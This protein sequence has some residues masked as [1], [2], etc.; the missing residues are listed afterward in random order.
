MTSTDPTET[1]STFDPAEQVRR[2]ARFIE[3]H[4]PGEPS[5]S[6]GAVDTAIRLLSTPVK[7]DAAQAAEEV[8]MALG[9]A[10]VCWG[11]PGPGQS[12]FESERAAQIGRDLL[13]RLGY[14]IPVGYRA[15]TA[16]AF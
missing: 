2:L 9:A 4:I 7:L 12:I 13:T 5:Q 14:S 16:A 3:Q 11:E 15:R 1:P 8:F 10:S 6:Q